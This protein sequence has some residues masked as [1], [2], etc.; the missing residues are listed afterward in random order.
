MIDK[1]NIKSKEDKLKFLDQGLS[2]GSGENDF[3][4]FTA[5]DLK[6]YCDGT[7]DPEM[8]SIIESARQLDPQIDEEIR[9]LEG[10][11][12]LFSAPVVQTRSENRIWKFSTI[13]LGV[14]ACGL[15][16]ALFFNMQN[17]P[18][19]LSELNGGL[20]TIYR[21]GGKTFAQS[22]LSQAAIDALVSRT[23]PAGDAW[24]KVTPLGGFRSGDEY[25]I[26]TPVNTTLTDGLFLLE[27]KPASDITDLKL[28][29][30][31][32]ENRTV[33]L[34][35]GRFQDALMPGLYKMQIQ[36]VA[37][38]GQLVTSRF[39]IRVMSQDERAQYQ[40]ELA[41][42]TNPI[43]LLL[44]YAEYGMR[45]EFEQLKTTLGDAAPEVSSSFPNLN[46]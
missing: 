11:L 16:A 39:S 31:G 14:A 41:Q 7:S 8:R 25:S 19:R 15:G 13:G 21:I 38:N 1:S 9:V 30:E 35:G 18:Q 3:L 42:V 10:E 24:K 36:G 37:S 12:D 44:V 34:S 46:L 22:E 4:E 40:S 17:A 43:D 45:E 26:S 33:P 29:I 2:R 28:V 6:S 32:S 23:I 20:T 27:F 5:D